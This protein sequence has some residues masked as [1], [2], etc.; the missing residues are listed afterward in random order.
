[1]AE[2]NRKETKRLYAVRITETYSKTIVVESSNEETAWSIASRVYHNS[3]VE[4]PNPDNYAGYAITVN[5]E[6][7]S[8]DDRNMLADEKMIFSA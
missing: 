6:P 1:M 5:P 7:L 3:E 4:I 8:A 2:L